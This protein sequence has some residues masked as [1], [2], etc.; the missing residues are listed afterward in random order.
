[1]L[2]FLGLAPNIQRLLLLLYSHLHF[3]I[4]P[5]NLLVDGP[6]PWLHFPKDVN[7]CSM[8]LSNQFVPHG[9]CWLVLVH[10]HGTKSS[11]ELNAALW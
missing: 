6:F 9:R 10:T 1:M 11:Y 4:L 5:P 7:R 3:F 2:E 8:D